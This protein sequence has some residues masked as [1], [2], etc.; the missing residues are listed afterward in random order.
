MTWKYNNPFSSIRAKLTF[1]FVVIA[2]VPV[3]ASAAFGYLYTKKFMEAEKLEFLKHISPDVEKH[4]NTWF[5]NH[6]WT[7]WPDRWTGFSEEQLL[8]PGTWLYLAQGNSKMT[9]L[10]EF[11]KANGV[12]AGGRTPPPGLNDCSPERPV[13]TG[14]YEVSDDRRILAVYRW[15]GKRAAFAN[16]AP[17]DEPAPTVLAIEIDEQVAM[18]PLLELRDEAI[19]FSGVLFV[20]IGAAGM[21]VARSMARPIHNFV[22]A[23]ERI[24]QGY[25]GERLVVKSRDEIGTMAT[26]FI[27]MVEKLEDV[28]NTLEERVEQRTRELEN[29]QEQLVRSEKLAVVGSL[30]ASIAHEMRNPLAG[31]SGAIQVLGESFPD[32]D[33]RRDVVHEVREQIGRLDRTISDLLIFAKPRPPERVQCNVRELI[34]ETLEHLKQV[35]STQDLRIHSDC[36]ETIP[37]VALD[38]AQMEQVLSNL[39]INAAHVV[40]QPNGLLRI[41]AA[42]NNGSLELSFR[43]NGPGID[44]KILGSIFEPFFT[45]K[46]R[47]TGLG[48]SITRKIIEAHGGSIA[49]RN[50]DEGGACFVIWLPLEGEKNE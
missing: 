29:T 32:D 25:L 19:L 30:A 24:R 48:L 27:L 22:G 50:N 11:S 43:D 49:A 7:E 20:L 23:T 45:T 46:H 18:A 39:I 3:S 10:T 31:I 35:P 12:S 37:P 41:G 6:T 21:L 34:D 9:P 42:V 15:I 28:Y 40:P 8:T 44:E 16:A 5:K 14:T 47:G 36:A 26:E 33:A 2:I 17:P 13:V 38:P 1:W 4:L